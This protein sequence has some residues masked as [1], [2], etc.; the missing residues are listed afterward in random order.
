MLE[1]QFCLGQ[2]FLV[3]IQSRGKKKNPSPFE[4]ISVAQNRLLKFDVPALGAQENPPI[5]YQIEWFPLIR[6]RP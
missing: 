1:L 3:L 5:S 4:K 2:E 6:G